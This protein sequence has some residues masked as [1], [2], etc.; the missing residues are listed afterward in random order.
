MAA[1]FVAFASTGDPNN[2][3]IPAWPAYDLQ[4][5]PTLIFD[6]GT[7]VE[8][9]PRRELRELWDELQAP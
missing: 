4:R 2:P 8:N 7:R 5:R 9:D 3:A 1:T 6:S